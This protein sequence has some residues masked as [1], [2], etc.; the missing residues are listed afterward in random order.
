[1]FSDF[2]FEFIVFGIMV[3]LGGGVMLLGLLIVV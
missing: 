2:V 3:V 1:M